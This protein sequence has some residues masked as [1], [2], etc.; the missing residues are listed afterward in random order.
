MHSTVPT[1]IDTI[2]RR[3]FAPR[4]DLRIHKSE[5]DAKWADTLDWVDNEYDFHQLLER[6][7]GRLDSEYRREY[8][9]RLDQLV[10]PD[11]LIVTAR[12]TGRWYRHAPLIF[13]R[14][15]FYEHLYRELE[16]LVSKRARHL[17][18][19]RRNAAEATIRIR[20][21]QSN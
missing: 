5:E 16:R 7:R 6:L 1:Y 3:V 15:R 13:R 10:E 17:F 18:E 2:A 9:L 12:R 14:V 4:R 19:K 8:G 11:E 20:C 21:H